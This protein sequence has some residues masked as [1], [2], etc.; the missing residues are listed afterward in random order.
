[1]TQKEREDLRRE[2]AASAQQDA[3]Q[4]TTTA[5]TSGQQETTDASGSTSSEGGELAT[6]Q[7]GHEAPVEDKTYKWVT[8]PLTE[9]EDLFGDESEDESQEGPAVNLPQMRDETKEA[10]E[11]KRATDVAERSEA[12]RNA[13]MESRWAKK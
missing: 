2:R 7:N 9:T 13:L 10:A 12:G 4:I 5:T 8:V 11:A 1:M 6:G 3:A